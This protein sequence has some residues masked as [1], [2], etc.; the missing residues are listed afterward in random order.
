MVFSTLQIDFPLVI[1][2]F[3]LSFVSA[4]IQNKKPF[5]KRYIDIDT[6][7]R[8]QCPDNQIVQY[9]AN[10]MLTQNKSKYS[11]FFFFVSEIMFIFAAEI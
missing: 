2:F 8:K 6:T 5:V 3:V 1:L 4:K 11:A 7:T 9:Y 10:V